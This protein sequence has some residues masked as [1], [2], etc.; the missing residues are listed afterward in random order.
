MSGTPGAPSQS[1]PVPRNEPNSAA[2]MPAPAAP[3]TDR[4]TLLREVYMHMF[5]QGYLFAADRDRM[6]DTESAF[7]RG[8]LSVKDL[9]RAVAKSPIYK[10]RFLS[11]TS[12]DANVGI[13]VGHLLGRVPD[14]AKDNRRWVCICAEDGY[15]AMV[16]TV[17]DDGEYDE[18]FGDNTVPFSRDASVSV[19]GADAYLR[20]TEMES[21][22]P[23]SKAVAEASEYDGDPDA[24]R[25]EVVVGFSAMALIYGY[26][27]SAA[28]I[29]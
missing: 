3:A 26:W 11:K 18:A 17:M 23:E 14:K 15:D 7:R 13:V 27:A 5:G 12:T 22:P 6:N 8:I 1:S 20:A 16:D 29:R 19:T 2:G 10:R 9:V 24:A 28:M 21:V 25:A 4:N